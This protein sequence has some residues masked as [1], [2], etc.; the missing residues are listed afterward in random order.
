MMPAAMKIKFCDKL[1]SYILLKNI[2]DNV[3]NCLNTLKYLGEHQA[4]F[5]GPFCYDFF[6]DLLLKPKNFL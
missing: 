4:I 6:G 5:H 2:P 3:Y 1:M